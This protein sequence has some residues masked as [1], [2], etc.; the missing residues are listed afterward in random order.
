MRPLP[1]VGV[2]LL[3]VLTLAGVA[4]AVQQAFGFDDALLE[5]TRTPV[6]GERVVQLEERRYNVFFEAPDI[7][8]P[9]RVGEALDDPSTSP[10]R[11]RVRDAQTERLL[12]LKGYSGTFTL[13]GDRDSTAVAS[14]EI[15]REGR[16]RLSV[17]TS[18]DL[19]YSSPTIALG[20]PIRQRVVRLIGG[21]VV[22]A[23][24]FLTG[25]LIL[26]VTLV[27]RSRRRA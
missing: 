1:Y 6:P 16:Y 9:D 2:V 22:A 17:T 20:E 19:P 14:V 12:D 13:S 4:F 18:D 26:I 27:V 8:D 5:G 10:L 25:L 7:Y 3:W 23:V 15:P 21:I 24:A 11:I